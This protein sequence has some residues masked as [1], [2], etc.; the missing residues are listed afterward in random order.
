MPEISLLIIPV[1]AKEYREPL[2]D[3]N[4]TLRWIVTHGACCKTVEVF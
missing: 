2:Q 1:L 4:D 3:S